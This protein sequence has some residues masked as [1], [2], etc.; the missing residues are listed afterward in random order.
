MRPIKKRTITSTLF[1]INLSKNGFILFIYNNMKT[2]SKSK[3]CLSLEDDIH[4]EIERIMFALGYS[5]KEEFLINVFEQWISI[6]NG[7]INQRIIE[8]LFKPEEVK[9]QTHRKT[10]YKKIYKKYNNKYEVWC[11]NKYIGMFDD[12]EEGYKKQQEML[13]NNN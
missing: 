12:I 10:K 1:R 3:I 6:Y 2:K 11:G 9:K 13:K 4:Y 5:D 8:K 7:D